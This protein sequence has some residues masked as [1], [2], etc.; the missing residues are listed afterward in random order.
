MAK[1]K[2]N[3]KHTEA[4]RRKTDAAAEMSKIGLSLNDDIAIVGFVFSH[5]AI[6]HLTYLGINSINRFCKTYTGVDICLFSQHI[7]QPCVP[8]LCPAFNISDLLR[9][10]HYPLIATSIGTTIEALSSNAPVVYHYAFDPEFIDKPHRESSDLK[11]A[12]CDPRVRVIVRHESHKKLIEEEFGIKVCAI[13]IPDCDI[14]ALV[15]FV[16]MEM[17]NGN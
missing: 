1:K 14:G 11:P 10:Y 16:L 17:K 3:P 4:V 8:L 7:I 5:L 13:I 15:K 2:K 6:S 12:F 9:W